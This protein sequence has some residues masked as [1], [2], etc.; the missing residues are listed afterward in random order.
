[1]FDFPLLIQIKIIMYI[2]EKGS[3]AVPAALSRLC[4]IVT[5]SSFP[6]M[7]SQAV[8]GALVIWLLIGHT[9]QRASLT[10]PLKVLLEKLPHS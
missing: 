6:Q 9:K 10:S 3:A 5:I 1:M 8:F 2:Y 7:K 4:L